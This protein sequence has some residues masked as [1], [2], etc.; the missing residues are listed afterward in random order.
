MPPP[1]TGK[2]RATKSA[3][4]RWRKMIL[5]RPRAFAVL[6]L[7][8]LALVACHRDRAVDRDVKPTPPLDVMVQTAGNWSLLLDTVGR[9][10]A[11]SGLLTKGP[12]VTDIDALMGIDAIDFRHAIEGRGGPLRRDGSLL[13]STTAPGDGAAYLAIDAGQHTLAAGM[14]KRGGWIT[15]QTPGATMILPPAIRAIVG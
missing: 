12:I 10:P 7:S 15:H 9:T 14:H 8:G 11:D 13:F 1:I 5:H 4:M 3:T 2:L 6:A